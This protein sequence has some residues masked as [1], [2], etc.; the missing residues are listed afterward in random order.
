[1]QRGFGLAQR[2]MPSFFKS[3]CG[4]AMVEFA[5]VLPF[6]VFLLIGVI[7]VGR[8]MYFGIELAHAAEAGAQYGSQ[9]YADSQNSTAIAAA[10]TADAPSTGVTSVTVTPS[11]VCTYGG[12][13][14]PCPSGT[15]APG[16][17][18]YASVKI[19]G[20]MNPLMH[21]PGIPSNVPITAST[22]MRVLNQ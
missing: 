8:Y 7:E 15:E 11:Q 12:L 16:Y 4:A 20:F 19:T 3:Q 5:V 21:Y 13:Q 22:T 9:T 14:T 10:V 1:M 17:T 2:G 18:Y 6:L